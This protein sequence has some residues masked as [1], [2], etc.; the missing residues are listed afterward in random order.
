LNSKKIFLFYLI[1]VIVFNMF[2]S[3]KVFYSVRS[4]VLFFLYSP[5]KIFNLSEKHISYFPEKLK[6][7]IKILKENE[8]LKQ[9]NLKLKADIKILESEIRELKNLKNINSIVKIYKGNLIPIDSVD[10]I[11]VAKEVFIDGKYSKGDLFIGL[12]GFDI[13][14]IGKV[15]EAFGHKT[16]VVLL[17]NSS[18]RIVGRV[19]ETGELVLVEGGDKIFLKYVSSVSK[20][21]KGDL[22]ITTSITG[23]YPEGIKIGKVKNIR[24][25]YKGLSFSVELT[26]FYRFNEIEKFFVYKRR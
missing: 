24:S 23:K 18:F 17:N 9:D 20:I 12:K 15:E 4:Y 10:I 3:K 11:D 2:L 7:R 16:R 1:L 21:K 13:Y 8:Y 25:F 26:P 22:I 19:K 5:Q 14:V 6:S